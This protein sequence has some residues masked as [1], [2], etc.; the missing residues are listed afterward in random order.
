VG[1]VGTPEE[2]LVIK[3]IVAL[4]PQGPA[5]PQAIDILRDA[6]IECQ[7]GYAPA[8]QYER[9]AKG[10][11]PVT[12]HIWQRVLCIP[13]DSRWRARRGGSHSGWPFEWTPT[14]A[15]ADAPSGAADAPSGAAGA[16]R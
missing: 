16:A 8:P 13:V 5:M 6:G 4:P 14:L 9:T 12:E 10:H 15:A 3:L 11:L 1:L 7:R 2:E